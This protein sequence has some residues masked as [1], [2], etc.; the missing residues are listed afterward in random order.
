MMTMPTTTNK[1]LERLGLSVSR[2]GFG[3]APIGDLYGLVPEETA[4]ETIRAALDGGVTLIDTAPAY[5]LGL[6]ESRIG[7]ALSGVPRERFVLESKVGRIMTERGL[8]FD[9]TRDGLERS[10]DQSLTRLGVTHLDIVLLHDPDD[11]EPEACETAL[12]TLLGWRERGLV[13]AVGVGMNQWQMPLRFLEHF[14]LDVVMVAGRYTLLEQ[15]GL[16]LLDTCQFRDVAVFAAGVFN[17]GIL[18]SGAKTDAKF[19]YADA[20]TDVLVRVARL[21]AICA[22]HGVSLA[23]AAI[24]FVL[25]HTAVKSAVLGASHPDEV[26]ANLESSRMSISPEFWGELSACEL[27]PEHV[28]TPT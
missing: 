11:L 14:D 1:R 26:R 10:L 27:L 15:G 20:P 12:P 28:P 13:R 22:R 21:E 7:M 9:L 3:S 4:L 6:C 25:A 23:A 16:A 18:A 8:R 19:N 17:T 5:S 24:Q 2:I